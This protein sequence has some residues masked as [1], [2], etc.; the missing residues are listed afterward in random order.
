LQRR[1]LLKVAIVK[2]F[3]LGLAALVLCVAA[4]DAAGSVPFFEAGSPGTSS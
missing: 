2:A 3:R 1:R 4:P